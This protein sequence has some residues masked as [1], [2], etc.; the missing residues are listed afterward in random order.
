MPILYSDLTRAGLEST[1]Y[2]T[3]RWHAKYYTT[4]TVEFFKE[5]PGDIYYN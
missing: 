4:D 3:R 2:H 1:I 5:A